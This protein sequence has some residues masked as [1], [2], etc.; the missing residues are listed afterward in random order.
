MFSGLYA[1]WSSSGVWRQN[2]VYQTL[3]PDTHTAHLADGQNHRWYSTPFT[4]HIARL[5]VSSGNNWENFSIR[6]QRPGMVFH[7]CNSSYTGGGGK[8]NAVWGCLG[9]STRLYVKSKLKSK[10]TGA[11]VHVLQHLSKQEGVLEFNLQYCKKQKLE[12][13]MW[14]EVRKAQK[15]KSCVISL[16]CGCWELIS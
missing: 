16:I 9:K 7:S 11:V 10:R 6:D 12:V 15:A 4:P 13:I 1:S 2:G 3:T 14:S 8:R 5:L